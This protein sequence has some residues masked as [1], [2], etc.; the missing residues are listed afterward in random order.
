MKKKTS[1]LIKKFLFKN[2]ALV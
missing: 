2:S 1:T